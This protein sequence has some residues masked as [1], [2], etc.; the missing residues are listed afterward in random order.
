MWRSQ[1]IQAGRPLFLPPKL[2]GVLQI[3]WEN[4]FFKEDG[5]LEIGYRLVHRGEMADPWWP[6]ASFVLP[7][8]TR[9]D[10][11]MA[12]RLLGTDLSLELRNL[13]DETFRLSAGS[14]SDGREMRLRLHWTFSQ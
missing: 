10:L 4:H 7:V 12:F 6:G 13:T 5:I 3:F 11:L 1:E 14:V 2:S 9:H 8:I